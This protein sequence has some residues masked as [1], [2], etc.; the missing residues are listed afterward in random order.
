MGMVWQGWW[1]GVVTC[2]E[3][4]FRNILNRFIPLFDSKR[5][6]TDKVFKRTLLKYLFVVLVIY[7]PVLGHLHCKM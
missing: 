1:C 2:D 3:L 4:T 7:L 5:S 6:L